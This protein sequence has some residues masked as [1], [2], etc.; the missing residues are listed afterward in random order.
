MLCSTR[1]FSL[2]FVVFLSVL[3]AAAGLGAGRVAVLQARRSDAMVQGAVA[4]YAAEAGLQRAVCKKLGDPAWDAGFDN[5]SFAGATYSV[6]VDQPTPFDDLVMTATARAGTSRREVSIRAY[7]RIDRVCGMGWG[8]YNG[9][10]IPAYSAFV[11]NPEGLSLDAAGNLYVADSGNHRVRRIDRDTSVITTVAGNGTPGFGGDNGPAAQAALD[12]PTDV[13]AVASGDI[14]IC[15][16]DNHCIRM[17]DDATGEITTVAGQGTLSGYDGDGG[18]AADALL[19]APSGIWVTPSG[20]MYIAD[21]DNHMVRKVDA[22]TITTVAGNGT[23]G[24]NG[25]GLP[26]VQSWINAPSG[27]CVAQN[28]DVYIADTYNNLVRRLSAADQCLYNVAGTGSKGYSGSGLPA[29]SSKL[30]S[31]WD[32]L[33]GPGDTVYIADLGNA[34]I[35]RVDGADGCLYDIAGCARKRG[36][37][38]DAGHARYAYL[39]VPVSVVMDAGGTIFFS[40]KYNA[41]VRKIQLHFLQWSR[42]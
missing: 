36:Y 2:I 24:Y 30:E 1:G 29:L 40:D 23:S 12:T 10:G 19:N 15:D 11:D 32:V 35:R 6:V 38:G 41:L 20:T 9:D 18:P 22:G 27:V 13:F 37:R 16:R 33:L 42:S 17:V 26:A 25:N 8:G 5:Q 3:V 31:P 7:L 28:G 34:L 21:T 39:N 4:L 14:Y